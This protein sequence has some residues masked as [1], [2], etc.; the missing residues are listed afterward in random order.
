[1]VEIIRIENHTDCVRSVVLCDGVATCVAIE[2]PNKGNSRNVSC[3]PAGRYQCKRYSSAKYKNTFEVTDVFGRDKIL[4]H[5][6]NT[7][8][9]LKG[10]IALGSSFGEIFGKRAVVS[11]RKAFNKFLEL[12]DGI[13]EFPLTIREI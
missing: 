6:G 9:D 11:S 2:R 7:I 1:M 8:D 4:F 5:T 13:D 12:L 10:C 3:I